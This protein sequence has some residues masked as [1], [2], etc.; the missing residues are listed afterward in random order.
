LVIGLVAFAVGGCADTSSPTSDDGSQDVEAVS[1]VASSGSDD[2]ASVDAPDTT[3]EDAEDAQSELEA[4]ALT[5]TFD[6]DRDPAGCTVSEQDVTGKVDPDAD[7]TLTLD[8]AQVDWEN[9]EGDDWDVFA[10]G[11]SDGFTE[12]C[13]ALFS[14]SNSG[15]LYEEGVSR[16]LGEHDESECAAQEGDPSDVPSDAPD[17]PESAGQEIGVTDGCQ[18]P[19][20]LAGSSDLY[21][22]GQAYTAADCEAAASYPANV[23]S[24]SP[25]RPPK[26][27]A[28]AAAQTKTKSSD[29]YR[30]H[31]VAWNSYDLATKRRAAGYFLANN[32]TDCGR[33]GLSAA[34]LVTKADTVLN[35][36]GNGDF[37]ANEIMLD[38]CKHPGRYS[39]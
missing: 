11:Y 16:L 23:G 27:P 25:T 10:S 18:A 19:F 38:V 26:P 33:A 34:Q 20:D 31:R 36:I 29:V 28:K 17:D 6:P 9:Q 15:S 24:A 5:V 14:L 8:C 7:V 35:G 39:G 22:E 37:M 4:E 12:G 3:G 1:E 30:V 32:P 2:E 13:R 21:E